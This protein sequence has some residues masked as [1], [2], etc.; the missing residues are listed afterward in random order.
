MDVYFIRHAQT[1]GNVARRHQ[2]PNTPLNEVGSEQLKVVAEEVRRLKPTHLITSTHVRALLT[3]REI[4]NACDLI[5]E[6]YPAF[7][8]F[9]RPDFLVGERLLS[10]VTFRFVWRWFWGFPDASQHDGESYVDFVRRIGV[11][12]RQLEELPAN[13]KVVVVSHSIFINFFLEHMCDPRPMGLF[14]ASIR[15]F[16]IFMLRNASITHLR[17][18][19]TR[20]KGACDWQFI[21]NR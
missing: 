17:Y 14:R 11:A 15:L 19:E 18:T 7:E 12:R 16:K 2:H 1:D 4:G 13:A 9:K 21:K 6:T 20:R 10:L 8:E 3:A 5:P